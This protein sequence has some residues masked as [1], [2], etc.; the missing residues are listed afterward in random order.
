MQ[1]WDARP[2]IIAH[3]SELQGRH[4]DDTTDYQGCSY[5]RSFD[6][7]MTRGGHTPATLALWD[8]I[9][10]KLEPPDGHAS[11]TAALWHM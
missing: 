2:A 1:D 10:S 3:F 5:L 9:S 7:Y 6:S 11:W 8:D 4:L